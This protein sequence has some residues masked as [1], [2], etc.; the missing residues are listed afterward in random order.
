MNNK[1]INLL[2]QTEIK[3]LIRYFKNFFNGVAGIFI[4]LIYPL[5]IFLISSI[6]CFLFFI[7][8]YIKK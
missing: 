7:L 1:L 2:G 8:T 4:E 5:F 3:K 6:V